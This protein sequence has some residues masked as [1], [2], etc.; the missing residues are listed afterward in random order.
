VNPR[1]TFASALSALFALFAL[2]ATPPLARAANPAMPPDI[3]DGIQKLYSGDADAS[4]ASFRKFQASDPQNPLGFLMEAEAAYWKMYC[5]G[6]SVR[7][8]M[9]DVWDRTKKIG[10]DPYLALADKAISL[11]TAA[12]TQHDSADMHLYAGLGWAIKARFHSLSNDHKAIAHNGV[13]ARE[14]FLKA[15]RLD[16]EMTDAKTGLGLY[17]YYVETLPDIVK[18][19]RYFMGIP[20]GNKK[21]G[22]EQLQAGINGNGLTSPEARFYL[23]KNLRNYD[24]QYDLAAAIAAPLVKQYPQNP[25]FLLLLGNLDIELNRGDEARNH[26]R[27]LQGLTLPDA[28]CDKNTKQ[29]AG[30]FLNTL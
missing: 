24:H 23:A 15:V 22:I 18:L 17:N 11:A 16:P 21:E 5:S 20:G 1:P 10:D 30:L 8:Q 19:L 25:I 27:A 29:I 7:F 12:Y 2:L 13:K 9:V 3:Q 6:L 26:L 4:I 28:A 14:E